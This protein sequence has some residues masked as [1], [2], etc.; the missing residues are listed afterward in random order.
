MEVQSSRR[1]INRL[2]DGRP[3]Q[4]KA[5]KQGVWPPAGLAGHVFAVGVPGVKW[6]MRASIAAFL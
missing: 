5:D 4:P 6:M 3:E 1:P 2:F